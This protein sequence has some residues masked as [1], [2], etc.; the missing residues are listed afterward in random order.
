MS[1]IYVSRKMY[2]NGTKNIVLIS[3]TDIVDGY[4]SVPFA[5]KLDAPIL[6]VKPDGI[7][8]EVLNEIERLKASNIYVIGGTNVVSNKIDTVIKNRFNIDV[9]RIDGGHRYMTAINIAKEMDDF[10]SIVIAPN[11]NDAI[12]AAMVASVAGKHGMP[13]FYSDVK[14]VNKD[15]KEYIKS[16]KDINNIYLS[17]GTFTKSFVDEIN[18]LGRNVEILNGNDRYETNVLGISKFNSSFK[19]IVLVDK[20]LML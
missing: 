6:M 13:I 15:L 2:P 12:D 19:N 8:N 17:G 20:M 18:T 16:N 5:S 14:V 1:G 10:S 7:T 4:L 9:K 3:Y 11:T